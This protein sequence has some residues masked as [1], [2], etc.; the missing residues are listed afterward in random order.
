M[1]L[2]LVED[3]PA[4]A[5]AVREYLVANDYVVEWVDSLAGGLQKIALYAYDC[6]LLDI[7]LPDGS[8]LRLVEALKRQHSP[9]GILILSAKNALDDKL[10]GLGLGADDYLT[11]PFALP[12]LAARIR[13]V[14]RRRQ[15][16]GENKLLFGSLCIRPEAREVFVA[17]RPVVLTRK[18]FDLLLFLA[19][20]A[21]RVLT[22]GAIAEHLYGDDV[23]QADSFAFLYSHV[24]NLR[25]KLLENGFPDSLR[26]IY[27]VGYQFIRP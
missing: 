16:G 17:D 6:V 20:N 9:A 26:T 24:K 23:D 27:G 8:G 25:K 14:L 21:G 11:K 15:F 12:E 19:A 10:A 7:L 22:K 3:E 5:D 2:L 1:K 18:E 13:S 4:L